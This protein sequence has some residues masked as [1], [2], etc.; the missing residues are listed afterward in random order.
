MRTVNILRQITHA[1]IAINAGHLFHEHRE[2]L[3]TGH[4]LQMRQRTLA[5][6]LR[7]CATRQLIQILMLINQRTG[8]KGISTVS[9]AAIGRSRILRHALNHFRHTVSKLFIKGTH[10]A[11]Q[12]HLI[13]QLQSRAAAVHHAHSNDQRIFRRVESADN[14]LQRHNHVRCRHNR[15]SALLRCS[16]R[17][18]LAADSNNEAVAARHT[19]TILKACLAAVNP[20]P[21]MHAKERIHII[22]A[23]L[24]NIMARFRTD[25][26]RHLEQQL[27]CAVDMLLLC[28]QHSCRTQKHSRMAIMATGVHH[29]VIL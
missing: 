17:R 1:Q 3:R 29:A 7:H 25:F 10:R 22:E 9:S 20:R 24:L 8:A 2:I 21:D 14:A 23:A 11:H 16:C 27:H 18:T 4:F 6:N 12:L 13:C 26:L 28:H 15:I 5:H 19:R